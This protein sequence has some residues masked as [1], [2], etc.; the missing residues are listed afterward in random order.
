DS[1]EEVEDET[2]WSK[3]RPLLES[4]EHRKTIL[5]NVKADIQDGLEKGTSYQKILIKNFNLW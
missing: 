1:Q 5:Q 3:A 2:K 4:K